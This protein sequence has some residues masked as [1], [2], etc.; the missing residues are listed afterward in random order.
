MRS[1]QLVFLAGV[2]ALGLLMAGCS[3]KKDASSAANSAADP[4]N[5]VAR[6][7]SVENEVPYIRDLQLSVD[8]YQKIYKRKPASLEQMVKE[9]FLASV[10]PAPPGK[11][12]ALDP[13]TARVNVVPQ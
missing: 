8:A 5:Q 2:L 1:N 7:A 3:R 4:A 12:F 6:S 11:R 9:G 13:A 10:P